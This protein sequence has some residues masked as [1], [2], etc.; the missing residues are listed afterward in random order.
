MLNEFTIKLCVIFSTS[1]LTFCSMLNKVSSGAD[2]VV[3]PFSSVCFV[4]LLMTSL[5]SF[6]KSV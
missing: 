2:A 6:G 1:V 4:S 3:A 5:R